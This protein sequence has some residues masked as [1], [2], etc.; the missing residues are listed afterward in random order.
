[1]RC[2]EEPVLVGGRILLL[3]EDEVGG[4]SVGGNFDPVGD[5]SGDVSDLAGVE[6]DLFAAGDAGA[7][8][9]AGT[10]GAVVGVFSLHGAADDEGDGAPQHDDLV[11]EELM[12]LGLASA[13][14]DYEQG[15][16]VAVIV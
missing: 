9:F 16:V 1:M 11:G 3:L 12:L 4:G 15:V 13:E 5:A 2:S 6:G 10:T 8:G 14:A 7:H